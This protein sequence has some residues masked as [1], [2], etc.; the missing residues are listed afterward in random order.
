MDIDFGH[1]SRLLWTGERHVPEITGEIQLEHL[2]R[3]LLAAEYAED[4]DVLDIAC[5]EGFGSV[6]L[7]KTARSVVGVDIFEDLIRTYFKNLALIS[8][9]IV[10]GS[11]IFPN[12]EV[13]RIC[14][15]DIDDI[16]CVRSGLARARYLIAV[17]SDETL[18]PLSGGLLE[19]SME[20]SEIVRNYATEC[21][22]RSELIIQLRE[23]I[24]ELQ[25]QLQS[26]AS[27]SADELRGL[28][29]QLQ[30]QALQSSDEV[31]NL[32]KQ[33][34]K[35]HLTLFEAK[36]SYQSVSR[37]LSWRITRP[38][39]VL[40]DAALRV[41]QKAKRLDKASGTDTDAAA[42]ATD[43]RM[44]ELVHLIRGS[45]L[46]DAKTYDWAVA[47]AAQGLDPALHYV[48]MGER[49]GLKPSSGFDPTYYGERYP[50][51][52]A[53]GGN[54]LGHYL[55]AGRSE[56]RRALPIAGTL[57]LPIAK[58]KPERPTVLV[59]I[60]EA[61]RTGAPILGWNIARELC[62]KVNVVAILMREGQLEKAFDEVAHAVV[63]PVGHE[64]FDPVEAA[65]LARRLT[66]TYRPLYV[67][68]NSVETRSLVPELTREA[69][70]VV[71]LVHEFSSRTPVGSLRILYERAAKI[72]FPAEIVRRASEIDY[73]FL[74]LRPTH[75]LPQGPSQVPRSH[76]LMDDRN[77]SD[78]KRKLRDRLRPDGAEDDIVVV[79]MG[80]VEWRK[81]IDLFISAATAVLGREPK[82]HLRFIW[83]IAEEC[84]RSGSTRFF[85]FNRVTTRS[86]A[87][88]LLLP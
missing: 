45:T 5:G 69:V 22:N 57:S 7:A 30:S 15:Y 19:Q 46:F 33:L 36:R 62:G 28:Q 85:R 68:A 51:V 43:P 84:H 14:D 44:T 41:L 86:P 39:R 56:G 34:A 10:Y 35:L 50:D 26:Q 75:V 80:Y 11:G 37:S 54:R 1:E 13:F 66:E 8:Q 73:P 72:V 17:A 16:R 61:S 20:K 42:S 67:I 79:G 24:R 81:G 25:K 76:S 64:L 55:E 40:F 87:P 23:T 74:R 21:D 4:K 31:C 60:H 18:P 70:P 83:V 27:Q 49:Q 47:A 65:N 38:L 63:G 32:Q 82:P 53:W 2:H 3:Y 52:A 12:R 48:L 59:L 71:A 9:R 77:R 29:E 78:A 88:S 58:I 6:I